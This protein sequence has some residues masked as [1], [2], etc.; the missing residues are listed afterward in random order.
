[1]RRT[2]PDAQEGAHPL[3]PYRAEWLSLSPAERLRRSWRLRSRI[4]DLGAV[5]DAKTFPEL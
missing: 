5:H 4:K 3:D 1:M 2:K